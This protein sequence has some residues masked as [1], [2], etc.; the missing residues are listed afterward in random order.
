MKCLITYERLNPTT[1]QGHMIKVTHL[2]SSYNQKE[3]NDL[4]KK[5]EK[6]IS[7]GLTIKGGEN[8]E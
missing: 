4:E 5:L 1:T 2:F 7:A 6:S 8:R 3:I